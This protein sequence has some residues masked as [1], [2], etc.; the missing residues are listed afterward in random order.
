[1]PDFRHRVL[2]AD[3]LDEPGL[4]VLR[5][6][7]CELIDAAADERSR[8]K[9]RIVGCHGLVV[10]S[11]TKVD[12]N[13]LAAAGD[14]RVIG[15][16][17][18]GVDNVDL[19][20]ATEFDVA[21]I[22][23]PTANVVAAT[24]LTMALILA[25]A[26]NLDA[27][28]R[29][30]A[31]GE[32][33]RRH[34]RGFELAGKTLGVI[35]FGRIGRQ[36]A[37]RG[38]AFGMTILATDPYLEPA[39]A[40]RFAAEFLP[41]DGLLAEADVVT[42]HT[43][44]SSETR[45]LIDA[46]RLGRMKPGALLINCA[47]GGILDENAV[48]QALD[49]GLLAGVGIDVHEH[50]P[51]GDLRL[52]RHPRV[53]ATPHI[54]AQTEEAQRR[55]AVEVAERLLAVL[56]G[57]SAVETVNLPARSLDHRTPALLRLARRLGALSAVLLSDG[58]RGGSPSLELRVE[59]NELDEGLGP[60]LAAWALSGALAVISGVEVGEREAEGLGAR[61]R[62]SAM[63]RSVP[64]LRRGRVGVLAEAD[65]RALDVAGA[66]DEAG[67]PV[68]SVIESVAT[69]ATLVGP[70]LIVTLGSGPP[71]FAFLLAELEKDGCGVL[72]L[73]TCLRE[74]APRRWL[75]LG[76]NKNPSASA[77]RTIAS[78]PGV[79]SASTLPFCDVEES[80]EH[81]EE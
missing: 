49:A 42:I 11:R 48:L 27:A 30:L 29:S 1:M 25:L 50:E 5:Q 63:H 75:I 51:P 16:S 46:K 2:L 56:E 36:V 79:L 62:V 60:R 80:E 69:R 65:Q 20:A 28:T 23:T 15:C 32:W 76:L 3:T 9:D 7:G 13:L 35:G 44:L 70:L 19:E 24:E 77:V 43:P 55:V 71:P 53:L 37:A 10:R 6:G 67:N 52:I 47:R 33:E 26:R 38:V 57:S 17:G 66:L 73:S 81:V 78:G 22:N 74:S 54:G 34:F 4:E 58:E 40:R 12:R 8:L 45:H 31:G 64:V 21:V 59:S 41:L 72:A 39:V 68:L 61:E 14:L 18:I